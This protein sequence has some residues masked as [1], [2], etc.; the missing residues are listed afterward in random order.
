MT[1]RSDNPGGV[2]LVQG[3]SRGIGLQMIQALLDNGSYEH[4]FATCRSPASA[5]ALAALCSP[6]K[7]PQ[8]NFRVLQL[9][10]LDEDSIA[11][12]SDTVKAQTGRV[13]LLVNCSGV[14]H[15]E[16]AIRPEKR[17]ADVRAGAVETS[18][19]INA[20][21]PLLVAR[22]FEAMLRASPSARFVALS[23]R[24]GSISDNRRGGWYAYRA[25]KAALNMLIRSLAIEWRRLPRPVGC[26]ALHP[27][28]VATDLTQ[29]FRRN[30]NPQ[31]IFAPDHAAEQ[32]LRTIHGLTIEQ[33]GGFHAYDGKT[34]DW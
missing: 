8:P 22:S 14:L 7:R 13:D 32:L 34:I 29:P 16:P 2:A 24:V 31:Q 21:G 5:G 3:A 30:L 6:R 27:G 18:F 17:L 9:D 28:T 15:D 1:W 26:F 10:V 23:A 19:K 11:A 20:L 12:A 33:T 4:V 25:S